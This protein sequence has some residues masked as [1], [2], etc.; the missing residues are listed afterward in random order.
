MQRLCAGLCAL[1]VRR[2]CAQSGVVVRMVV[3]RGCAQG[4]AQDIRHNPSAQA[5]MVVRARPHNLSGCN[6]IRIS[7][8]HNLCRLC[9]FMLDVRLLACNTVDESAN[10]EEA[11]HHKENT[12]TTHE[13]QL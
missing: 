5:N 3:R 8:R 11:T 13:E 6:E 7:V 12:Q 9:I 2:L 10:N 1:L 4:C